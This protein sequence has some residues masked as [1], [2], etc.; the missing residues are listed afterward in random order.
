MIKVFEEQVFSEVNIT[1]CAFQF[2]QRKSGS[3]KFKTIIKFYPSA[4]T[5]NID[6]N[7]PFGYLKIFE[8]SNKNIIVQRFISEISS[9]QTYIQ[10]NCVDSTY[11][12]IS[13]ELVKDVT[14]QKKSS[15][16]S[17]IVCTNAFLTVEDQKSII[18]LFNK[19]LTELRHRH[20]SLV[21]SYFL[22]FGRKR[23]PF[24]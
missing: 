22:G 15:R 4:T 1:V 23:I 8:K 10:I 3:K 2:E 14:F 16:Y 24:R 11:K 20:G 9:N 21:F 18:S 17:F 19:T 13:A 5:H 7:K 6:L 12:K